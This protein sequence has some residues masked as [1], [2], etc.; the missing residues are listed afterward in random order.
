MYT[1]KNK[2]TRTAREVLILALAVVTIS[3]TLAAG[4]NQAVAF[5]AQ[6]ATIYKSERGRP[7]TGPSAGAPAQ[8]VAEFLR[9]NGLSAATVGSL[10]SVAQSRSPVTGLT[11]VRMEQFVNGLRVAGAY[12]KGAVSARGEVMHVIQNAASLD[13][14]SVQPA[15]NNESQALRSALAAIYPGNT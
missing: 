2:N 6:R 14:A 12:V 7:L 4:Q 13:G 5:D 15:A 3:S 10:Q 1:R 8:R 9:E 11:H